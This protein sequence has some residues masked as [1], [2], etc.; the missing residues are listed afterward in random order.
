MPGDTD[1]S[2]PAGQPEQTH[3][4]YMSATLCKALTSPYTSGSSS[5][6]K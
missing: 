4:A 6:K 2:A 5:S 1:Q 3:V